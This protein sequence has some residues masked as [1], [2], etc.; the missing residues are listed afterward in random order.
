[1]WLLFASIAWLFTGVSFLLLRNTSQ[2]VANSLYLQVIYILITFIFTGIISLI[3][4]FFLIFQDK[5]IL[6]QIKNFKKINLIILS[7][8]IVLSYIF[9]KLSSTQGGTLAFQ[10][11]NLNILISVVG[12]YFFFKERLNPIQYFGIVL[13]IISAAIIGGGNDI[14]K[15]IK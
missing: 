9:L 5:S 11:A 14:W 13:A 3:I 15:W 7:L 8:V 6:K 12:G 1:M 4:L 10:I 2:I